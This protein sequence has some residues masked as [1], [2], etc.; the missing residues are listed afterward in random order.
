MGSIGIGAPL[1]GAN[2]EGCHVILL[3]AFCL[4]SGRMEEMGESRDGN[5]TPFVT[6]T[7]EGTGASREEDPIKDFLNHDALELRVG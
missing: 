3:S 5:V 2:L 1:L 6:M 4:T 7:G